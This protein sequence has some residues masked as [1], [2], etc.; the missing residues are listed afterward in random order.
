M[1]HLSSALGVR[2]GS[3]ESSPIYE[4][5]DE[6]LRQQKENGY[7]LYWMAMGTGDMEMLLK[8]NADF[9]KEMDEIGMEYEYVESGGGHTW[10]NWRNYLTIFAQRIFK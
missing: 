6:K 1:V 9:R 2:P 5:K 10:D 8:G 4:N 7:R 3:N